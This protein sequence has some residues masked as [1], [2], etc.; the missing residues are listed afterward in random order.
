MRLSPLDDG[1][2]DGRKVLGKEFGEDGIDFGKR[3]RIGAE[4]RLCPFGRSSVSDALRPFY[5]VLGKSAD[6]A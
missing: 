5:R 1:A 3:P 4:E 2:E 6:L